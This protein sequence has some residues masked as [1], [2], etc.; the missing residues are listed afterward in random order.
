MVLVAAVLVGVLAVFTVSW[1]FEL[2]GPA[3]SP[4]APSPN[5]RSTVRCSA[6]LVQLV[7]PPKPGLAMLEEG[8]GGPDGIFEYRSPN[9][10]PVCKAVGRSRA[11]AGAALLAVG[12][13]LVLL[14]LTLRGRRPQMGVAAED[15]SIGSMKS[16]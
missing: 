10:Q 2:A 7:D 11:A 15:S 1:P 14:S 12:V 13:T 8:D 5:V 16:G 6:P 3:Y 4:A 9:L